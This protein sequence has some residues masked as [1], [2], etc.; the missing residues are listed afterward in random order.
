MSAQNKRYTFTYKGKR[1]SVFAG[2]D[3]EAGELI[4]RKKA[5]I[6]SE[7]PSGSFLLSQW[8]DLCIDTYKVNISADDRR[9]YKYI[10]KTY[11]IDFVGD[12]PLTS[13]SHI[14]LQAAVNQRA[15]M[16]KT[17]INYVFNTVRFLF[18]RAYSNGLIQKDP[19]EGL[20]KPQ[21]TK[22]SR[23]ALTAE[24]RNAVITVASRKRSYF[25]YLLM[26]L[27]G[28]RPSEAYECKGS[29]IV[30][31]N[32][33]NILHVRGTKTALSDRIVPIPD[34]LFD[35]I[36][37]TPRNEYISPTEAGNKQGNHDSRAWRHFR[38][39][40]DIAL[41]AE[42]YRNQIVRSVIA[43]DLTP[44]CLRHEYCT[45]LARRGID[46]RI[47]QKL[48]GH[49]TIA[50]TANIYTNLENNDILSVADMLK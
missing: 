31:M 43:K 17:H 13:Y 46:I 33:R 26:M 20:M 28:C 24:E 7:S 39:H 4:A 42:T 48:M 14:E 1:H 16:S 2:S 30:E 35:L 36:K 32:G 34:I 8:S 10:A 23:R 6:D 3:R 40:L 9:Y 5:A 50:L 22:G 25:V 27:C 19:S 11:I 29:D 47:A 12:K 44:Y 41:G 21:G 45:E 49:S 15:G 18:R 38:Y 37:D